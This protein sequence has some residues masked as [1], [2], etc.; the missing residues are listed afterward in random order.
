[1]TICEWYQPVETTSE[2]VFA[3]INEMGLP[4]PAQLS[5]TR[6]YKI[7]EFSSG[8]IF[9]SAQLSRT[10]DPR[11]VIHGS[12]GPND[13]LDAA[14]EADK[15]CFVRALVAMHDGFGDL[16]RVTD[17]M[18]I[19][20]F[21]NG[22]ANFSQHSQVMDHLSDMSV[23]LFGANIGSHSRTALGA[24]SL[25]SIGLVEIEVVAAARPH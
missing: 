10:E 6:N 2:K 19:R 21:S 17:L 18:H 9:V 23:I 20:G 22:T 5:P 8:L 13:T 7:A 25:P 24:G 14:I 1:M 12:I 4:I 16:E 3:T 11:A 15:V